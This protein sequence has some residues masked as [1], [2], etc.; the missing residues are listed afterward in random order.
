MRHLKQGR[1]LGKTS[2]HRNAMLRNLAISLIEHGCIKTTLPKAK[3]LRRFVEP[4]V[5]YAKK[6]GPSRRRHVVSKLHNKIILKE[7]FE[8]V[9]V[10]AL[11]RPG[12]YTRIIKAGHRAGDKAPMA[13]IELVDKAEKK[14]EKP[15][16]SGAVAKSDKINKE[17][18]K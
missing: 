18:K 12:G 8:G 1:K 7:V 17:K 5:T 4:I 11:E 2:A 13:Y 10:R 15:E 16:S 14:R 6:D 9:A 3:E